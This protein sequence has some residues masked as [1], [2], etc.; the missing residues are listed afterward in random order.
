MAP[1]AA[2]S[3]NEF[4]TSHSIGRTTFYKLVNDGKIKCR[5]IGARTVVLAEDAAAWRDSLPALEPRKAA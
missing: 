5:R 2:F 1:K 3:V 4:L